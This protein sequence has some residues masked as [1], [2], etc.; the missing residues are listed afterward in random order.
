MKEKKE[1]GKTVVKMDS[2]GPECSGIDYLDKNPNNII[3]PESEAIQMFGDKLLTE[4]AE[5]IKDF[6]GKLLFKKVDLMSYREYKN[7]LAQEASKLILGIILPTIGS[8]GDTIYWTGVD[9]KNSTN[10]FQL[11]KNE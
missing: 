1:N 6:I 11:N 8:E 7:V 4:K 5:E 9:Q 10:R 3:I 2:T